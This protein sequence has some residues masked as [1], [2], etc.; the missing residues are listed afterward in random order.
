MQTRIKHGLAAAVALAT[1][2][3]GGHGDA[4]AQAQAAAES[5]QSA[6][7]AHGFSGGNRQ[8]ND[9][10][11]DTVQVFPDTRA[12]VNASSGDA[13]LA[14]HGQHLVAVY[15]TTVANVVADATGAPVVERL[16]RTGYS[17]SQ[18]GGSNWRS[19][20]VPALPGSTRTAGQGVVAT[21]RHGR[22]Y[23]AGLGRDLANQLVVTLNKSTDGGRSFGPALAVDSAPRPDKSWLAIGPDPQQRQRDNLYLTW[24]QFD[25]STGATVL[26]FARSTDG[27]TTFNVRTIFAPPPDPVQANPQNA[28]QFSTPVVDLV[29]GKLY[30]SLLQF[31]NVAQDYLLLMVSDDAG[32]TF[33]FVDF[34][35]PG[36]PNPRVYP[37][38]QPGT[39]TE[40]SAVPITKPDGSSTFGSIWGLVLHTGPNVGGAFSANLPRYVNASRVNTQPALAVSKGVIHLAWSNS[41]SAVFG[42]PDSGANILYVRSD[43][44]GR[45]WSAPLTVNPPGAATERH[46]TPAITIGRFQRETAQPWLPSPKDVLI[47]YYSQRTDGLIGVNLAHSRNR[48]HSFPA[49]R[50][51]PLSSVRFAPA[52][53]N[54]P[55][56]DP[57][58][59]FQTTNFNRLRFA[60]Q[61]MGEVSGL[62][63]GF[64]S[65]HAAWGDTRNTIRQ[66]DSAFDPIAGQIHP[67]EDV[68][69]ASRW[70]G[71]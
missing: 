23:I 26:R 10:A 40:C 33:R 17:H 2:A 35:L 30:I 9:P 45:N 62:A 22:F 44:D 18:D 50:V 42:E 55:L 67:K 60:C 12:F 53:T 41:T 49:S 24:T 70:I 63:L 65:V 47:S 57:N 25:D 13:T 59:P 28:I 66:P 51:R 16:L 71:W 31:G 38:V 14:A 4:L 43:D 11:A 69:Y 8:I 20:T 39:L 29:T 68:F 64:G 46:V 7:P 3:C 27:G 6:A 19:G 5:A 21:D 58:N 52:P 48:G 1:I 61:S 15:Q 37:V 36:A 32:K 54:V 56:P 34:N